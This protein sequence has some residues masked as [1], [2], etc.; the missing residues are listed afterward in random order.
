MGGQDVEEAKK[1]S[2][3]DGSGGEQEIDYG[4]HSASAVDEDV[5]AKDE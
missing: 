5:K 4:T 2:V 3:D 1:A